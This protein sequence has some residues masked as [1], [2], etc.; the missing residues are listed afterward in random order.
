MNLIEFLRE[1]GIEWIS[2]LETGIV[3]QLLNVSW[4]QESPNYYRTL[5]P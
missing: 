1:I 4:L 5:L 3:I 2:F